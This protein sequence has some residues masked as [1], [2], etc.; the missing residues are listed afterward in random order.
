MATRKITV[1]V[2]EDLLDEI[3]AEASDRGLSAYIAEALR[4]KLERDR[5]VELAQWLQDE[6]GPVTDA[7]RSAALAEL[8]AV[9]AEH[10]RRRAAER[11]SA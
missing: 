3:R 11:R 7:E 5:L 6:H 1:T 2:P 8:A 9:D 4:A 10:D